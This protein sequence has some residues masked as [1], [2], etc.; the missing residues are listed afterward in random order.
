MNSASVVFVQGIALV[1]ILGVGL[2]LARGGSWSGVGTTSCSRRTAATP[3]SET[4]AYTPPAGGSRPSTHR[5]IRR[6]WPATRA[7]LHFRLPRRPSVAPRPLRH[8]RAC[9][10]ACPRPERG[11]SQR[12]Q[13]QRPSFRPPTPRCLPFR[14][15]R[16]D[17]GPIPNFVRSAGAPSGLANVRMRAVRSLVPPTTAVWAPDQV[18]GDGILGW[19]LVLRTALGLPPRSSLGQAPDQVGGDGTWMCA[20]VGTQTWVNVTWARSA[21]SPVACCIAAY[22]PPA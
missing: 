16:L 18:W 19:G 4:S 15:P 20:V 21:R 1:T 6:P 22:S 2:G 7:C 14:R 17:L 13:R 3:R 10:G 5:S 9:R 8:T 11:A 12:E